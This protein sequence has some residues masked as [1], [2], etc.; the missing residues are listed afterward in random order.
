MRVIRA[1]MAASA[2]LTVRDPLERLRLRRVSLGLTIRDLAA[3]AGCSPATIGRIEQ[4]RPRLPNTPCQR[5]CKIAEALDWSIDEL[6]G[7]SS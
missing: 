2:L 7:S 3:K 4:G 1:E 6:L 5:L